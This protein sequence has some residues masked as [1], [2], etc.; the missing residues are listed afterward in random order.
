MKKFNFSLNTVLDYK[1]Q[2]LDSLQNEHAEILAQVHEQEI[3]LNNLRRRY[4]E[5][6]EDYNQQQ[7]AG[8]TIAEA[9]IHQNG[10][11]AMELE[12]DREMRHLEELRQREARKR[13]EVVEAKK[14]TSSI[15]KLKEKKLSQY[16]KAIQ[17]S[18]EAF[19]DE[20]VSAARSSRLAK[21]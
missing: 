12:I 6:K 20:F 15:E 11:H 4:R 10:L 9:L 18:E 17:K 14:E 5:S 2:V 1:T 7:R 8:L 16:Q 13:N 19:I 3:L 21:L